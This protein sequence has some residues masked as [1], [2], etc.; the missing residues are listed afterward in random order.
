MDY[1]LKGIDKELWQRVKVKAAMKGKTVK[2]VIIDLL[3]K[4]TRRRT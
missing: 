1:Y 2:Q 3:G 4:W